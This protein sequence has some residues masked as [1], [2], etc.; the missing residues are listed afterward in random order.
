MTPA[1]GSRHYCRWV[2]ADGEGIFNR[3]PDVDAMIQR[4]RATQAKV[5]RGE[6]DGRAPAVQAECRETLA[7][8]AA[9]LEPLPPAERAKLSRELVAAFLA[10]Q[11]RYAATV[12]TKRRVVT[13][14]RL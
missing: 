5:D 3:A 9:Y 7:T 6:L 2:G 12:P 4:A 8:I 11:A 13:T 10:P 1:Y 14:A